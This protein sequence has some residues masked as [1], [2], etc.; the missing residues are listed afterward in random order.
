M[1]SLRSLI[2]GAAVLAAPVMAALSA[3]QVTDG[4]NKVTQK[5][6]E[7]QPV[8]DS[9]T[10]VNAPLFVIGQGPFPD[11]IA[12]FT[13]IITTAD[14]LVH[15]ATTRSIDTQGLSADQITQ[16]NNGYKKFAN[17]QSNL[18]KTLGN[19]APLVASV[20][21]VGAPVAAVLRSLESVVDTI[22]FT[23][24]GLTGEPV[25]PGTLGENVHNTMAQ[26]DKI[27]SA[28]KRANVFVA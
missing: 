10:V 8:A 5:S 26:F 18:L 20:P 19:K 22:A 1:I 24:I 23:I 15:G 25:S 17:A 7:L 4:L 14:T 6:L 12:G 16:I 2:A 9:I 13:D 11:L 21:A 3:T 27:G 28:Q